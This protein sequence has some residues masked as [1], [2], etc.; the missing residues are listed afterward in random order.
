MGAPQPAAPEGPRLAARENGPAR[1]GSAERPAPTGEAPPE[2]LQRERTADLAVPEPVEAV[3]KE[4]LRFL[5]QC[6][7][8]M[9]LLCCL[10]S[11]LCTY[12]NAARA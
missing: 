8:P 5:Y 1:A 12:I 6:G 10:A 3:L 4:H 7:A 9:L 11:Q 2:Q